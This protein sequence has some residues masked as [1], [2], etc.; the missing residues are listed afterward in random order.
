M[1]L[2]IPVHENTHISWQ[3]RSEYFEQLRAEIAAMPQVGMAGISTNATP[4]I[5]WRRIAASKSSSHADVREAG[6]PHQL[7][8]SGILS[9]ASH[10]ACAGPHLGSRRNHARR[11]ARRRQP[12]HGAAVLA[13]RRRHRPADPH[14]RAQE[15]SRLTRPPLPEATRWLQVVGIVA[16]ARDDGLRNPVK[17]ALYVPYTMQMRMFTQILVRT[18]VPPLAILQDVARATRAESTRTAGD[19]KGPRP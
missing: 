19:R 18:Q 8:Q 7:R 3:D 2:P 9:G 17:P 1:S 13:K 15:A 5:E 6:N 16:D 11:R 4:P 12:D 14:P 10:S